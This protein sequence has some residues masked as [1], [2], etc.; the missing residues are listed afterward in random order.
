MYLRIIWDRRGVSL[1]GPLRNARR[2]R[3]KYPFKVR[4]FLVAVLLFT[5]TSSSM[6]FAHQPVVLLSTDTTADKGPLLVDGT[7]SFAIRASFTKAGQRKAFRA[8]LKEGEMLSIQYLIVDKKPENM[9]RVNV[10]P[11]FM[12]TRPN[13][14]TLTVKLNERTKFYE[15]FS[16]VNY[17]YLGRYNEVAQTGIYKF[18]IESKAK[19]GITIG[20]GD[21]EIF[22][23][24]IR[25][26]VP[27]PTS[28]PL[29]T[30][31][32]TATQTPAGYTMAQVAAKNSAQSC[33]A[34]I[35]AQV[36]DLTPWINA[37]PGGAGAIISLCGLDATSA[38]KSKHA[39]QGNPKMQLANL[40]I[41]PLIK[42]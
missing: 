34:V 20:I 38:F 30:P 31:T 2:K 26:E 21:K 36:Y 3:L 4:K 33:W 15:P 23:E 14:S 11:T 13:G 28:T 24:V 39:N 40:K 29:P 10:L 37:H 32:S 7:V 5:V 42:G 27:S 6:A 35:D 17:F 1:D 18:V 19:T 8:Q 9:L 41:G 16:K 12:I 25:G 22:G